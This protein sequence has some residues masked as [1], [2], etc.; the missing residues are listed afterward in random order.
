MK[1]M[2]AAKKPN[3]K[4]RLNK[5][6]SLISTYKF[7][8]SEMLAV[9]SPR[10]KKKFPQLQDVYRYKYLGSILARVPSLVPA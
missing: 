5:N 1:K 9:T 10:N 8:F 2:A 6:N 7:E 4:N 3:E